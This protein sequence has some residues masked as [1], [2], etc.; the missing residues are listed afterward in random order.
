MS[1][2]EDSQRQDKCSDNCTRLVNPILVPAVATNDQPQPIVFLAITK[3]FDIA[4]QALREPL[5]MKKTPVNRN[6]GNN[7]TVKILEASLRLSTH[8]KHNNYIK[9]WTSYSKNKG[10]IEVSHALDFL[11]GIFDKRHAH[12]T[13]NS[14]KYAIATT[15]H[16]T[17]LTIH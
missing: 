7:T 4:T 16:Y 6:Q 5:A 15:V 8:C 3:K 14:A 11:S 12:S 2:S 17:L 9:Q 13:N 10:H 1:I